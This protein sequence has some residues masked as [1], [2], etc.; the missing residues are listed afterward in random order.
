MAYDYQGALN[1]GADPNSVATYL[2]NKQG[3]DLKGALGAGADVNDVIRYLSSKDSPTATPTPAVTPPEQGMLG[4]IGDVAKATVGGIASGV[5]GIALTAEDYLGRKA[6]NAF[7]TDQ[8]KANLANTPSLNDQF[9]TQVG[10]DAHPT[11]FG[12]GQ[13][14]GEVASLATP[15]GAIGTVAKAGA[16]ALGAGKT[17]STLAKAGTEGLA[18][19][20]GQ[21]LTENKQQSLSD[22]ATNAGINMLVPGVGLAAKAIGESVPARI[23]NSLIK[24]LAKDFAYG[25]NP[26]QT[27]AEMGITG[28]NFDD[29]IQNIK[30]AKN[31]VGQ[32]IGNVID[33]AKPITP[34]D[35]TSSLSPID[36]AISDASKAPRTNAG[37][38]QR[39]D[40]IKQD[41]VD[42]IGDGTVKDAQNLKGIVGDLTK[43]TGNVSDDASVNKALKGVYGNIRSKMDSSLQTVLSP[44]EFNAY[45]KSADQYGNLISAEN[46]A[47]YRDKILNRQD[48]ISFGAK[49]AGLITGLGTAIAT[50][51]AGIPAVLAGLAGVGI[52]KVMATPAF[53][54]RL[55][56]LLTKLAPDE[57]STF[58]S[59]V[60]TAKSL[61]TAQQVK[62]FTKK[63]MP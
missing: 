1:A 43:W 7:G 45:K 22:Y 13:L 8:M 36:N 42:N 25:K 3:Y 23:I 31:N 54:T 32:Q 18:F 16:E 17:V 33:N 41:I 59:K 20:A 6:V 63:I 19:T 47:T 55:A 12:V 44:D 57:V 51:G 26:G 9:K 11:A 39:L 49:N 56:S 35:L 5:G 29:L 38:I 60:P 58:F 27:V 50:G 61:F 15:V 14:G 40:A 28:N 2:A 52:D 48:L 62:D 21:G 24:P 46:A 34:I 4:K 37:L 53:K 30:Q 10:G